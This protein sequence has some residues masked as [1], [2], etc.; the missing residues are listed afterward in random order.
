LTTQEMKQNQALS[1]RWV[2]GEHVI[3][4]RKVFRI[5]GE[6]YRN[7]RRRFGLRLPLLASLYNLDLQLPR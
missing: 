1:S 5:L 4:K 2:V 7:R 6:K 3:G